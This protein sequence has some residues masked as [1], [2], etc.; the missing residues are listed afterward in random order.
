MT[1]DAGLT[2]Q[3]TD[4]A[5][6]I[7][8]VLNELQQM[9]QIPRLV[10]SPDALEALEREMRQ[11][12]DC[13]GS[14]LVGHHLQHAPDSAALQAE[15]A[16]LVSQWPTPLHNDGKVEVRMR[17]AQGSTVPVR[18]SYDR[19]KGQRR[20]VAV[21]IIKHALSGAALT[22]YDPHTIMGCTTRVAR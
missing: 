7:Q 16:Q 5:R 6:H 1:S 19:R 4:Y 3:D 8:E 18:V 14:F 15:H 13:L 17:T 22:P 11:C 10:T 12:T 2:S 9:Q 21:C 20:A